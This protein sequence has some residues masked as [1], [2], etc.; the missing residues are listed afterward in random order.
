MLHEIN[1]NNLDIGEIFMSCI[2]TIY[3]SFCFL[4]TQPA[5]L[6]SIAVWDKQI[7]FFNRYVIHNGDNHALRN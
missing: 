1:M 2:T 6:Q 4:H 5:I 3:L 7:S